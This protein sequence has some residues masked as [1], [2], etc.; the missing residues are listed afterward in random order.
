MILRG[1]DD[2]EAIEAS[3]YGWMIYKALMDKWEDKSMLDVLHDSLS[4]NR[5]YK[6]ILASVIP[7]VFKAGIAYGERMSQ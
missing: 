6:H 3:E 7:A 5:N 4:M 1:P 2:Q